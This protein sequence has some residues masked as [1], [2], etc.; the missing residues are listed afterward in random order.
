MESEVILVDWSPVCNI[1][2]FVETNKRG[3]VSGTIRTGRTSYIRKVNYY[4]EQFRNYNI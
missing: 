1:Q 2:A 3:R 4:S